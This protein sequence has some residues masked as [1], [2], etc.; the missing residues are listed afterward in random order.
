MSFV[1]ACL[2]VLVHCP[3]VNVGGWQ[4]FVEKVLSLGGGNAPVSFFF[5]VSGWMLARHFSENGWW[6]RALNKRLHSLVIPFVVFCL[7]GCLW[8]TGWAMAYD[9]KNG[10][11][12]L[13]S[14]P[15]FRSVRCVEI[16]GLDLRTWPVYGL[17]WYVRNLI[18]LVLCSPLVKL[19]VEKLPRTVSLVGMIL[20]WC[21]VCSGAK[22]PLIFDTYGGLAISSFL[23]FYLGA[24]LYRY[25][26]VCPWPRVV[27]L[28]C[29]ILAIGM[30]CLVL[31]GCLPWPNLD[32]EVVLVPF[33]V[34]GLWL[35]MP[36]CEWPN[37]MV[38]HSF[39]IYCIHKILL[40]APIFAIASLRVRVNLGLRMALFSVV[41]VFP[42]LIS[43][44]MHRR[45]PRASAFCFG[46]R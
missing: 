11:P 27:G 41:V 8:Q 32:Y 42:L 7:L 39:A 13:H 18:I 31:S 40:T 23:Y 9:Y 12:L 20:A 38:G 22:L 19:V 5:V 14:A 17:F 44:F 10:L 4:D 25:P 37:W 43:N 3:W 45:F 21:V 24:Y 33:L 15:W 29:L 36:T 2:V 26:V 35:L 6:R 30:Q 46:G 16:L 28:V 34:A 1:C